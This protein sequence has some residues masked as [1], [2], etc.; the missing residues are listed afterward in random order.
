MFCVWS[1]KILIDESY[2]VIYE[3]KNGAQSFENLFCFSFTKQ[4]ELL[5]SNLT[6]LELNDLRLK[7][8]NYY[9]S[10]AFE[11]SIFNENERKKNVQFFRKLKKQICKKI[12]SKDYHLYRNYFCV[13]LN[14]ESIK[15]K[16]KFFNK[17]KPDYFLFERA[18]Y[19]YFK[20]DYSTYFASNNIHQ[21]IVNFK[22]HPYSNCMKNYSKFECLNDC[23]K[24][25]FRLSKYRY[26]GNESGLIYLNY[27]NNQ[28]INQYEKDCFDNRCLKDDCKLTHFV[29][30]NQKQTS[31]YNLEPSVSNL[32]FY[33]ELI[34]LLLLFFNFS[35]YQLFLALIR[36]M[37]SKN[38]KLRIIFI[39]LKLSILIVFLVLNFF[40]LRTFYNDYLFKMDNPTKKEI[41]YK[42]LEPEKM[43]L[44][45]C[46]DVHDGNLSSSKLFRTKG[47]SYHELE[48]QSNGKFNQT[49]KDIYLTFQNR[50]IKVDYRLLPDV[51]FLLEEDLNVLRCFL[52]VVNPT[53][54]RYQNLLLNT[55]LTIESF[56]VDNNSDYN[57]DYNFK[58]DLYLL[59]KNEA[60]TAKSFKFL[61]YFSFIKTIARKQIKQDNC[62]NYS[63][64]S[65]NCLDRFCMIER[66]LNRR[67]I[68]KNFS[69]IFE[70]IVIDKRQFTKNQWKKKIYFNKDKGNEIYLNKSRKICDKLYAKLDCERQ[71]F[72]ISVNESYYYSDSRYNEI[73]LYYN[74][75]VSNLD[76]KFRTSSIFFS[77]KL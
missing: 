34:G 30:S 29:P 24:S 33:I 64:S 22:Q 4:L 59:T 26:E 2:E 5:L 73:D 51:Y 63:E 56:V 60:F 39:A 6:E 43:K 69:K 75:K 71:S 54:P 61:Q 11:R 35:F 19:Y 70:P 44:S 13:N 40:L 12:S 58:Y 77:S 21:L 1:I 41:S 28:S 8:F 55:K 15:E 76:F 3:F 10:S 23:F 7:L 9:N 32:D 52:V 27:K 53:V 68:G 14:F 57:P 49:I 25:G 36:S 42:L 67:M 38:E 46:V 47:L 16:F 20:L 48:L 17:F 31:T 18:T 62:V 65:S 74:V 50:I 37:K 72:E 45:V 66:C